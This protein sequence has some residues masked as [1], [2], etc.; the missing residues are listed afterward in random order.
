[1]DN[2]SKITFGLV[3]VCIVLAFIPINTGMFLLLKIFGFGGLLGA[4]YLEFI[5]SKNIKKIQVTVDDV[6]VDRVKDYRNVLLKK[7]SKFGETAKLNED[8]NQ[9]AVRVSTRRSIDDVRRIIEKT[10]L[11]IEL[12][13]ATDIIAYTSLEA[14]AEMMVTINGA[15]TPNSEV[16]ISGIRGTIKVGS[17][18]NFSV[19][20]PMK[21]VQKHQEKGYIPATCKKGSMSED[22]KISIK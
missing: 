13:R 3:A 5:G 7:L 18:G 9:T 21:L 22:I 10:N 1:M 8:R 17:S 20:V 14:S 16:K 2:R 11:N 12:K 15:T 6:R 4:F 19:E